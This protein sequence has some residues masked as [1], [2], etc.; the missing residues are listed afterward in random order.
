MIT[1]EEM[2]KTEYRDYTIRMWFDNE[3]GLLPAMRF[4]KLAED[5]T[6]SFIAMFD[7]IFLCQ[8]TCSDLMKLY[9][10]L[11]AIEIVDNKGN[12]TVAYRDWP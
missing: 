10:T 12:G 7:V 6:R 11:N 4:D 2:R 9:P 5:V 8:I 1:F 3:K